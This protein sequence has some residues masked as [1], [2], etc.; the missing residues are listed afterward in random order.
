MP[1]G[2][3]GGPDSEVFYDLGV[4]L[5]LQREFRVQRPK[6]HVNCDCGR[7]IEIGNN[8]LLNLLN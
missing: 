4:E 7:F 5:K 3:I 8:V 1:V 2:E 6:C